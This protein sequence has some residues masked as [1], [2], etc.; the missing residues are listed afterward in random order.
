MYLEKLNIINFRGIKEANINFN[1][2]INILIGSNNIGKSAIIDTLR[3]V[4]SY[5]TN[6]KRDIYINESDFHISSSSVSNTIEFHLKFKIED[7]LEAGMFYDLLSIDTT[8]KEQ[9]LKLHFKYTLVND[10]IKLSVWGGENEGHS[11][12]TEVFDSIYFVYL[13]ALRDV[14]K[15]MKPIRGNKLGGLYKQ[16]VSTGED[17]KLVEELKKAIDTPDWKAF[18]KKGEEKINEHLK[19]TTFI[20]DPKQEVS[21]SPIPFEFEK[22]ADS[23][24]ARIP[25][26]SDTLEL[27]QNG[28]G[29]NNL[30]Y[31][32]TV[33]GDLDSRTEYY[34]SL[35][36]EEP[37]AHLHPQLQNVLFSY[38]KSYA[39]NFQTFITSHSPTIT[40]KTDLDSLI[41]INKSTDS[42]LKSLS[43]IESGLEPKHKKYLSKFLD[44]TKS[45]LFFAKGVILVEGISEALLLPVFAKAMGDEYDLEKNAIEVVNINGVAFSHFAYLFNNED[46]SKNIGVRA[47]ILTDS[48]SDKKGGDTS[49]ANRAKELENK[50]LKVE[51]SDITFENELYKPSNNHDILKSAAK[52]LHPIS[53]KR[54]YETPDKT[55]ATS[56]EFKDFVA[57]GK[58]EFAHILSISLSE[59]LEKGTSTF[60]VPDYIQEA[61]KWVLD[62]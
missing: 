55:F 38:L 12:S 24:T 50:D 4:F 14:E 33:L 13:G 34:K 41:V 39:S 8:T 17:K 19:H 57:D 56:E 10:K 53:Y 11:I 1:K 22:I 32:A 52:E 62:K 42:T 5:G 15:H 26:G 7:P 18:I 61:I 25:F 59:E 37:E 35:L 30:I 43:L 31:T 40:A 51:V 44:V 20:N 2:N 49:R 58:S 21:I 27:Y 29:Y 23:M 16:L 60:E 3:L 47:S 9:S 54:D 46:S 28:L 48:D 6:Q 36:I 45:Q